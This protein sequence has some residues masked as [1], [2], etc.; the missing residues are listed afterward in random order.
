MKKIRIPESP[1]ERKKLVL[2]IFFMIILLCFALYQLYIGISGVEM[3][4]ISLDAETCKQ[5]LN[6]K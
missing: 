5:L 1:S 3:P 6:T 2:I 4:N